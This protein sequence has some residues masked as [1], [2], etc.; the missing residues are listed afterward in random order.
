MT[1]ISQASKYLT[2]ECHVIKN[3]R[4]FQ[5]SARTLKSENAEKKER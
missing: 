3:N 2:K 1:I 4:V 5:Y